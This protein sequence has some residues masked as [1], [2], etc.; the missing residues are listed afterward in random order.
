MALLTT[1]GLQKDDMVIFFLWCC[2]KREILKNAVSKKCAQTVVHKPGPEVMK[3]FSC[4]AQLRLKIILLINVKIPT[5]I[6]IL[7]LAG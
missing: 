2:T 3:L 6:G 5:I 7:T 4:S 1:F